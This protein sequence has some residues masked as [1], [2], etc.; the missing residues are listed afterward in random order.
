MRELLAAGRFADGWLAPR[1]V[2][3]IWTRTGGT[4]TLALSLP[5]RAKATTMVFTHR[6]ARRSVLVRPGGALRIEFQV[7]SGGPWTLQFSTPRPAY[8][9]NERAVSVRAD[10]VDFRAP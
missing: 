1:G 5:K 3:T 10:A 6:G 7:P 4:L 2:I 8:L 9:G